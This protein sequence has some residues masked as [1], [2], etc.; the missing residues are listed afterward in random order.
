MVESSSCREI[1]SST[2]PLLAVRGRL[3][4]EDAFG[5]SGQINDNEVILSNLSGQ[6]SL[7]I[8]SSISFTFSSSSSFIFIIIH[9]LPSVPFYHHLP[10]ES[11][12]KPYFHSVAKLAL[13]T[14]T[15]P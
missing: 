12:Q 4:A 2:V 7:V 15:Q 9:H 14:P 5:S 6:P 3:N 8:Q 13:Q 1:D 11:H 10:P